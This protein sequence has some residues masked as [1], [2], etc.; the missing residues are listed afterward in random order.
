M[1]QLPEE[2]IPVPSEDPKK[3]DSKEEHPV[4][5][6]P[7]SKAADAKDEGEELVRIS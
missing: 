5:K 7:K 2:T 4:E 1:S 3:K 6:V